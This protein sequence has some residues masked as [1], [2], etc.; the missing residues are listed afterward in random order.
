MIQLCQSY[1][2][3]QKAHFYSFSK[4]LSFALLGMTPVIIF[5]LAHN[6]NTVHPGER[7]W[8][9]VSL[10]NFNGSKYWSADVFPLV[11]LSNFLGYT[12]QQLGE[13]VWSTRSAGFKLGVH[14]SVLFK[15][16]DSPTFQLTLL[17][18][19]WCVAPT[20]ENSTPKCEACQHAIIVVA[21]FWKVN[22]QPQSDLWGLTGRVGGP[23]NK[24]QLSKETP[25][26]LRN[27]WATIS[28]FHG[29]KTFT[30]P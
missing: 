2:L 28:W 7:Y 29:I 10:Q 1:R 12:E 17:E 24:L 26:G 9:Q 4:G 6:G 20:S 23:A 14:F 13:T 19:A 30:R 3:H 15:P 16:L 25:C 22:H 11:F 21:I 18:I 27:V 5:F 8:R